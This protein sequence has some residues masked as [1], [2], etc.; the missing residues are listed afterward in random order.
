MGS[1]CNLPQWTLLQRTVGIELLPATV[2]T[3]TT[4]QLPNEEQKLFSSE[5]LHYESA[6]A[7]PSQCQDKRMQ[8]AT[9]FSES[10]HSP[11]PV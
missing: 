10:S 11:M 8:T 7:P 6:K 4:K 3:L 1:Y 2:S 5:L 9:L